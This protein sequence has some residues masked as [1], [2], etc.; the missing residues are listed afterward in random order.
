MT[1]SAGVMAGQA[2][3]RSAVRWWTAIAAVALLAAVLPGAWFVQQNARTRWAREQ[4]LPQIDQLAEREQYKEAFDLVQ[5]AK[6]YIPNDPVWK[7]ID[8]VVSRTMTVRT[9]PEGAAVSYRRVGSD[10]AWIPLGASP[11]ASA[12]VPNSYLEWQFAKEGYVTASEAV[13][14]GIAPSVTLSITLHAEKGTPPGMVYVPADDPPRV[15]LIAGLD[16]LPPQ[17]IRSFWIDRHEV[18]NADYKRFVDAGGYREPKYWTEVFA[19]G[20]RA[21]TF[22]QAVARFTDSTGRPGP[23]TWESGHFPEGQDDLPV[24]GVSW[25]EASAYAAFA[26]KALPTSTGVASRTSV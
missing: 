16:H 11:I 12:V 2:G 1:L 10:G 7:R 14:A 4:A 23:A 25:Y 15:A 5:Q 19:E 18:T 17:P 8:P 26:N 6:Q 21:L 9:T 3:R 20:G 13:A 22:A 24:T